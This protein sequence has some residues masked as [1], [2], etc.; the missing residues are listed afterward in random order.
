MELLSCLIQLKAAAETVEQLKKFIEDGLADLLREIGD[1]HVRVATRSLACDASLSKDK[2]R[3]IRDALSNLKIALELYQSAIKRF[4]DARIF[5]RRGKRRELNRKACLVACCIALCYRY[6]QEPA[7][8]AKY[9]PLCLRHFYKAAGANEIFVDTESRIFVGDYAPEAEMAKEEEPLR[10]FCRSMGM[11]V[12]RE[13][14]I[15]IDYGRPRP[16]GETSKLR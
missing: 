7:L 5:T 4:E 8:Q 10:E 11:E 16:A 1:V 6:L 15:A 9:I 2:Q 12:P 14:R 3:E 13:S